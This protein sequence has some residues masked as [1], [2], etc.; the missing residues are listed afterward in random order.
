[1][2]RLIS[3]I[4]LNLI[5]LGLLFS[6]PL[7]ASAIDKNSPEV[8]NFNSDTANQLDLT[9]APVVVDWCV[10]WIGDCDPG[11]SLLCDGVGGGTSQ[12]ME[13]EGCLACKRSHC[14]TCCAFFADGVVE[15]RCR[16][17]CLVNP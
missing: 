4:G 17:G 10:W 2:N 6:L 12:V 9:D 8:T 11:P 3:L 16:R 15:G 1:M 5:F 7:S 14:M 13:L